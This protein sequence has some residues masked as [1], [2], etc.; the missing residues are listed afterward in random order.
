M[1]GASGSGLAAARRF[2]AA[3]SQGCVADPGPE[4]LAVAAEALA[5]C[6]PGGAEDVMTAE[7]SVARAEDMAWLEAA[8]ADTWGEIDVLMLNAG[9]QLGSS[10]FGRS[11]T[12]ADARRESLRRDPRRTGP[13]PG[14]I[15][16][17]PPRAIIVTGAKQ[18]SP[19]A[20][21]RPHLQHLQGGGEG[22][23]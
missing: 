23:L 18:G 12:G 17:G 9:I 20:A 22:V 21:G 1:G 16:R 7:A 6:A 19:H 4:R 10:L 14:M 11:W 13:F 3:G 5:A 15:A 8:M 2:A